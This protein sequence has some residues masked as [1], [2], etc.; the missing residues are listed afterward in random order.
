MR[1]L[2][3]IVWIVHTLRREMGIDRRHQLVSPFL[4]QSPPHELLKIDNCLL[5]AFYNIGTFKRRRGIY[6]ALLHF[7]DNAFHIRYIYAC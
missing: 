3:K 2:Q 5:V 6:E 7:F 1:K 4:R